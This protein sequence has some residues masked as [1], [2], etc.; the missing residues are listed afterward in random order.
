[1]SSNLNE[2][3]IAKTWESSDS[4]LV[5][6]VT[7]LALII[8]L[9]YW[10]TIPPAGDEVNQAIYALQIAQGQGYPLVGNDAYAGPFYFYLLAL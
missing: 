2:T 6:L 9:P 5:I 3:L 1:M 10:Q 8:R 4:Y 7:L